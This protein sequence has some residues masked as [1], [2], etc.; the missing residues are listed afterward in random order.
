MPNKTD[1]NKETKVQKCLKTNLD[2]E[3]KPQSGYQINSTHL[4]FEWPF[5]TGYARS[6]TLVNDA[7][8]EISQAISIHNTNHD[9]SEIMPVLY[10]FIL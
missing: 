4:S 5:L 2:H 7:C 1:R 6:K 9:V 3:N 10:P 8:E